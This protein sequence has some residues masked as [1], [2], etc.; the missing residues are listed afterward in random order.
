MPTVLLVDDER[1]IRWTMS[2]LLKREGYDAVTAA[3][4]ESALAIVEGGRLDAA[5]VDI[6]LPGRS[7]IELLKHLSGR[8]PYIPVIMITG[9]PN[10][11][12]IPELVRAGAYDFISKPVQIDLL[13][14]AVSNAVEKKR[15][16]DEKLRLE[17][18]VRRH[19]EQLEATVAE[20]T[21]ELAEA[22]DFLN[23]VL[24]SS[25]EYA[26]IAVDTE[27]RFTLFNRGAELMFGYTADEA[28]QRTARERLLGRNYGPDERPLL[29]CGR[30]SE[31][32]GRHQVELNLERAT[33][34]AFAASLTMTPIRAGGGQLL[35]YLGVIKDL[36]AERRN[37]EEL[38]QMQER[39]AHNEKIAALGRMAAQ[40][41][42]EVKNPLAGLRLYSLHLKTKLTGKIA[43][44]EMTLIDKIIAVVNHLSDTAE[45]ILNFARPITLAP[46]RAGVNGLITDVV[47]LLEPQLGSNKIELRLNLAQPE[48]YASFDE[49]AMR[50]T[51][52]NLML[53]SIQAMPAGGTLTVTPCRNGGGLQIEVADTGSGMTDEQVKSMFEPFYTTKSQGLG[54]GMSYARKV[55][56]LHGG[57][58]EV[59]SRVGKGTNIKITMPAEG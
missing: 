51:L 20:R 55:V 10:I 29:E 39:L 12:Q 44:S 48:I 7:G 26:I 18:E 35:G 6:V 31:E 53:N 34:E 32:S 21:R 16:V 46:R 38:R 3:D 23:T 14:R 27:G 9:E 49:S 41:A 15:L 33:G 59:E 30:A 47:E 25:T 45:Q 22:H 4:V 57:A 42:H 54:L 2:E 50:S 43:D 28:L 19:A 37:Q 58:I 1:N 17:S 11:S 36:T 8:E 24:D 5:V 52:I 13:L 40:V 56:E